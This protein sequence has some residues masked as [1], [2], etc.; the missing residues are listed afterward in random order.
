MRLS[1]VSPTLN[2]AENVPRLVEQIEHALN[3]IDYEVLIVDDNSPDLTWAVADEL[4][5]KNPRVRA[6]RRLN[7][8]GLGMAVIEGF[9]AATGEMLLCIDADLQHDP[10]ILSRMVEELQAG[11]DIVVGSRH[12]DG[13][14]TGEWTWLRRAESWIAGNVAE[15]LLGFRL[16]DPM[17]GYFLMWSKDFREVKSK[18]DG[19]GFKI[20]LEILARLRGAEVKEVPYTFRPRTFGESKLSG[21]VVL[22][23]VRQLWRLCSDSRRAPVRF[24]KSALVGSVG[25]LI[26]LA[27]MACLLGLTTLKDWRA[28]AL[29]CLAANVQNYVLTGFW[30]STDRARA[31]F[32]KFLAYFSYMF[33]SAAGLTITTGTYAGLIWSLTRFSSFAHGTPHH[34]FLS[35]L[36]CELVAVLAGVSFSYRMNDANP[37]PAFVP[38]KVNSPQQPSTSTLP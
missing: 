8:P 26:N 12:I 27:V 34:L 2:E 23:F 38:L 1:V 6:I 22:F 4:S 29:A 33:M 32:R 17:S 37:R 15:F 30:T 10:A 9:S 28:S 36:T 20:L 31:G 13:G 7:A 5:F 11:A 18:L 24:L 35:R 19:N 21:R 16:R 14:S 25:V 3:D